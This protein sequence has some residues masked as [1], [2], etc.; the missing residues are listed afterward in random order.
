MVVDVA[1][2]GNKSDHLM[3]L[4]D[5]NQARP[6]ANGENL[7]LQARRP[8]Q[9]YQ[10]VQQAYD[11]GIGDYRA[12]QAKFERRY[13]NGF[14][15]LNSFT[16][17]RTRDNASGHLETANGD[18]SRV[19]F[20]NVDAEFGVSG[21]DQPL[22]N[23]TT[24]VW[25]VPLGRGAWWGD[26]RVT[27]VNTMTSGLPVNLNYS[28]ASNFQ[29]SGVVT[30]RPNIIGEIYADNPTAQQWFNPANIVVPTDSS[31]PFGNAP[32]NA[33]RGPAL[34]ST[35]LGLQKDL[36]IGGGRRLEFRLEAFNVFNKTNLG[37]PNSNRSNANFGSITTL[38]IQPR[39][40]QLGVKVDF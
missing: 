15:F 19:N 34:Y 18:N 22:N 5:L 2:I 20:A 37:A 38:A 9:G 27:A 24:A 6:N 40:V 8:I 33:A 36:R 32:R 13:S 25:E 21:Y 16:W 26:W 23:T 12:L 14:Y 28:P 4:A 10:F 35:D 7:T 3:I 1:Y 17:S 31:Q 39:Q 30:H 29:V 11:G